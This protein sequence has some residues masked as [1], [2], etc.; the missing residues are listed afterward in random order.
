MVR[1]LEIRFRRLLELAPHLR[2]GLLENLM[3]DLQGWQFPR[4]L[5]SAPHLAQKRVDPEC[6]RRESALPISAPPRGLSLQEWSSV[7]E[8]EPSFQTCSYVTAY[9]NPG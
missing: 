4:Q 2:V 3:V 8:T 6:R 7:K 1:P 5:E 9:C